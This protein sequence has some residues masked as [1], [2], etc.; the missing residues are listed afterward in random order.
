MS[1]QENNSSGRTRQ[2]QF[3][4]SFKAIKDRQGDVN[5]DDVGF[6]FSYRFEQS[7]AITETSHNLEC[8]FKNLS[9]GFKHVGMVVSQ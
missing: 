8:W 5:N 6:L 9:Y 4:R 7:L 3:V 2:L 1:R